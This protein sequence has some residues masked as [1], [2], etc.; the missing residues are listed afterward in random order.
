MRSF[1]QEE[2]YNIYKHEVLLNEVSSKFVDEVREHMKV[3]AW[4]FQNIFGDSLRIVIPLMADSMLAEIMKL[5]SKIKNYSGIDLKKGEVFRKVKIDPKYGDSKDQKINIGRVINKLDIDDEKK[6]IYLNYLAK[7]KD[8]ITEDSEYSIILSRSPVDILRMGEIGNIGHCHQ[9]GNSYFKCAIQEAKT[10]G[11]IAFVVKTAD[12]IDLTDE[13]L[14]DEEIFTD[15]D[16]GVDGINAISR[17]RI[18]KYN[19]YDDEKN[20]LESFAIPELKI[21]GRK[22]IPYFY[23]TVL[24]FLKS[25]DRLLNEEEY[26][27]QKYKDGAITRSGGSY[28]DTADKYLLKSAIGDKFSDAS[29]NVE[30]ED[31]AH[32]NEP[33]YDYEDLEDKVGAM[34]AAL[35]DI[36]DEFRNRIKNSF[37]QVIVQENDENEPYYIPYADLTIQNINSTMPSGQYDISQY[38]KYNPGS[39][40]RYERYMPNNHTDPRDVVKIKSFLKEFDK[41]A[42]LDKFYPFSEMDVDNRQGTVGLKFQTEDVSYHDVDDYRYFLQTVEEYSKRYDE[43]QRGLIQAL[44]NTGL[45]NNLQDELKHMALDQKKLTFETNIGHAIDKSIP[46]P[47][48]YVD[49]SE[50]LTEYISNYWK[51]QN[52]YEVK[53]KTPLLNFANFY[54]NFRNSN[55]GDYG[56]SGMNIETNGD[57]VKLEMFFDKIDKF[58]TQFIKFLDNNIDDIRNMLKLAFLMQ[59]EDLEKLKNTNLFKAYIK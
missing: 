34:E 48:V 44:K 26:L 17:M 37:Y 12:I 59:S 21:Y 32:E 30:A 11:A 18:R 15:K 56:L 22:S 10:G 5:I 50:L 41:L 31:E 52:E 42:N 7:Y 54:E 40:Y 1:V 8:N 57:V 51:Y 58:E 24:A 43:I 13:Q 28:P 38:L 36:E 19:V 46:I 39:E 47:S 4:P 6:T 49:F 35:D 20:Y 45:L 9:Q 55:L 29:L 53:E 25:K 23:E 14:E 16:R 33:E 2:I 27:Y 3:G